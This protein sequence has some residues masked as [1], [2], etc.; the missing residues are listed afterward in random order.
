LLKSGIDETG[1]SDCSTIKALFL[2]IFFPP[3]QAKFLDC[4]ELNICN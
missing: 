4:K 2:A 1:P 3:I